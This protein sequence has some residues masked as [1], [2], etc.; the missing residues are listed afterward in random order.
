M[1]TYRPGATPGPGSCMPP[2]ASLIA[3]F[4]SRRHAYTCKVIQIGGRSIRGTAVLRNCLEPTGVP[5]ATT[6][7]HTSSPGSDESVST[8][9]PQPP[10]A[11]HSAAVDWTPKKGSAAASLADSS[12]SPVSVIPKNTRRRGGA[13]D[14]AHSARG[15]PPADRKQGASMPHPSS[16]ILGALQGGIAHQRPE[17]M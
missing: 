6:H 7:R 8:S 1:S 13:P 17:G 10:S 11:A 16:R 14:L 3:V 9:M 15:Q 4:L 12:A 5:A 2:C